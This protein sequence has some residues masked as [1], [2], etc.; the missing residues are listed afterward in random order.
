MP[1]GAAWRKLFVS[2]GTVLRVRTSDSTDGVVTLTKAGIPTDADFRTTPDNGTMVVDT[3]NSRLYV[4][5]AAATW[6]YA[7]LV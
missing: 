5:V 7:A 1:V 4:R 3:T 2:D 6:K